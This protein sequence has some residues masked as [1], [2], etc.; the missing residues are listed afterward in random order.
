MRPK[1]LTQTGVGATNPFVVNWRGSPG[2]FGVGV[3]C[4]V[5]GSATYNIEICY[6]NLLAGESPVWFQTAITGATANAN[7]NIAGTFTAMRLNVTAGTGTVVA[8]VYQITSGI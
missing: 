1:A 4:E 7:E 6:D 8:K 5:T 2:G 3:G